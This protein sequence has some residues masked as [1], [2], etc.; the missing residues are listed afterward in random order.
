MSA[1]CSP[2]GQNARGAPQCS[3]GHGDFPDACDEA[4]SGKAV[5]RARGVRVHHLAYVDALFGAL[6]SGV[7]VRVLVEW[8]IPVEDVRD[9]AKRLDLPTASAE[10]GTS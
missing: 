4:A 5:L 1:G 9:A 3:E 2:M 8:G 10:R 7:P 6:R